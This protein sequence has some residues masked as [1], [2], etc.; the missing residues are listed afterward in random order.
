MPRTLSNTYSAVHQWIRRVWGKPTKCAHCSITEGRRLEWA[1][2]GDTV[3][4]DREDW[5]Q[6]CRSCHKIYDDTRHGTVVW[7]KGIHRK[8]NN[9]L[10]EWH[11]D[12]EVWNKGKKTGI[13]PKSAFKKG[14]TPWNKK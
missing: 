2:V 3:T 8:Y 7:N 5:L 9:A 1:T 6:L 13:V 14:Y 12:N 4:R 10:Q 11:K